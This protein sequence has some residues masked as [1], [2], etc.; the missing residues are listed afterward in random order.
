LFVQRLPDGKSE[1]RAL[2]ASGTTRTVQPGAE[3]ASL[4]PDG[5]WLAYVSAQGLDQP[6]TSVK[7]A[8]RSASSFGDVRRISRLLTRRSR[9]KSAR[10]RR[11]G[12]C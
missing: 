1:L 10:P 2:D 9:A 8:G 7:S 12:E 11:T 5:S 3:D 6:N 4:S